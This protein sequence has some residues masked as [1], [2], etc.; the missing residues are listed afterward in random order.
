MAPRKKAME[1][2]MVW[3]REEREKRGKKEHVYRE[4]EKREKKAKYLDCIK[5]SFWGDI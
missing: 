3:E 1:F 4:R 2:S 5:K